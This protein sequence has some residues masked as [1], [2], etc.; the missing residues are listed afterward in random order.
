MAAQALRERF[1]WLRST[2][3]R[4]M[5]PCGIMETPTLPRFRMVV[6]LDGSEYAEIV[7][8]H[9]LD[10]ASRHDRPDLHI[11]RVVDDTQQVDEVK[12]WLA[13]AVLE[14]LETFRGSRPDWRTR[15]HV[16][17][18]RAVDEIVDL[19]NEIAADLVV[20]GRYGNYWLRRSVAD[21]VIAAA[22]CP[23]LVVGLTQHDV[24]AEPQCPA[25]VAVRE[26]SDGERWFCADHTADDR[27]RLSTLV[28]STTMAHGGIW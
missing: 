18:G 12:Q 23:T 21:K 24:E 4:P 11:L 1:R 16:R 19:A 3:A 10:Q 7:L 14:G 2:A 13:A 8:E 9:A 5:Q 25:C 6:A 15:L 26:A 28:P 22:P 17:A 27:V 20:I